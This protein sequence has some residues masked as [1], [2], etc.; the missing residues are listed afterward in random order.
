MT[1]PPK[2]VTPSTSTTHNRA[3]AWKLAALSAVALIPL[4]L[5]LLQL[6]GV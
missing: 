3:E 6:A 2:S 4:A 1:S 5:V